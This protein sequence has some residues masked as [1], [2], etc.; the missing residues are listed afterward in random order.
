M[1]VKIK[2]LAPWLPLLLSGAATLVL[3]KLGFVSSLEPLTHRLLFQARGS[4]PWREEI[5]LIKID[6]PSID[7]LGWFPWE[8][9][10]YTQLVNELTA[11]E[12]QTI[13]FNI[14]FS[15]E[16][17]ED[18]AFAKAIENHG[19][20][21]LA[22]IWSQQTESPWMPNPTLTQA[23]IEIG[24]MAQGENVHPDT[25][26]PY[27]DG[28]PALGII[29]AQTHQLSQGELNLLDV[30][31]SLQ[32]HWPGSVE[33]LQ[34]YSFVDVLEQRVPKEAL[35]GK[36]ALVGMTAEGFDPL[37][38]PIEPNKPASGLHLHAAV[39]HSYLQQNFLHKPAKAWAILGLLLWGVTLRY[40]FTR[41]A[42]R[43]QLITLFIGI[44]FW[45]ALGML[46]LNANILLPIAFPILL[47]TMSGFGLLV[48]SNTRLHSANSQLQGK[49]TTDALTGLKNRAFFN[50]YSAYLW[51][52][53]IREKQ[54]I[55][56]IIC[57]I[58]HFKQYNDTY[59][60]LAG[61]D[62][63]SQVSQSLQ[64]AVYRTTD[65]VIRYGGEEFVILL[66][67]SNLEQGCIIAK[68][69]QHQ[70]AQ[71]AIPHQGSST[72]E[73]VT[74]SFGIACI[75]PTRRDH[76]MLLIDQADKA[77]YRAK[78]EGRDRYKAQQL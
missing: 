72:S 11:A 71:Q 1:A 16:T 69:I 76:L 47:L 17:A 60:H 22:S 18:E 39:L 12:V 5:V 41:M 13:A 2:F 38:S 36:I 65:L 19:Q 48:M 75:T 63:L 53:S 49:A 62:C 15:E 21:L 28:H 44:V 78:H 24:H 68:R 42:E 50:D 58:D 35:Q 25:V 73:Q 40:C 59:G 34:Q 51:R 10:R 29:T 74:L 4:Q 23:A 57:D 77:L 27:I 3:T 26:Q 14:L 55:C 31:D 6:Q 37:I 32:P 43:K 64:R 56:I 9:D 7:A 61:D 67:N 33:Q 45:P 20:V 30:Q 8:R 70:L 52:N 66:P 46:A 54:S